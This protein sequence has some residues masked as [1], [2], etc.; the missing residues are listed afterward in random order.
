MPTQPNA[1][2]SRG[3]G[4]APARPAPASRTPVNLLPL[5][6]DGRPLSRRGAQ[7]PHRPGAQSFRPALTR[8]P[9]MTRAGTSAAQWPEPSSADRPEPRSGAIRRVV[10]EHKLFCAV[11]LVA[12]LVRVIAM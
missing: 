10:Q 2:M 1:E 6:A 12:T 7:P 8:A 5:G 9:V 4:P 11:L 3:P